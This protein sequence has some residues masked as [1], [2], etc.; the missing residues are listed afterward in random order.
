VDSG[1]NILHLAILV[2]AAACVAFSVREATGRPIT[3]IRL[4]MPPM[5]A[6]FIA[7]VLLLMVASEPM[8]LPIWVAALILGSIVGAVRGATMVV[9]VDQVWSKLRMPNG[10]HA[11]WIAF[12]LALAVA[13][14]VAIAIWGEAIVPHRAIPSAVAALCAGLLTGRAVAVVIRVPYAPNDEPPR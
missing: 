5:F 13:L 8:A 14:E 11:F 3:A 7:V 1:V 9:R 12:A 10:R 6:G 4:F 2:S